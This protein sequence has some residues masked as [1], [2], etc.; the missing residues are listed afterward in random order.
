MPIFLTTV[1]GAPIQIVGL[2]EGIAD[3]TASV[4]KVISGWL[5]DKFKR[6][7]IFVVFVE[8]CF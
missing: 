7:K 3:S 1:L 5:S 6:R 4:L 2:I 8:Y